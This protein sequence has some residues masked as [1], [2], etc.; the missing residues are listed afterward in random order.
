[1][2][3]FATLSIHP[4]LSF[5]Y[6]IHK[7]VLYVCISVAALQVGSSVPQTQYIIVAQKKTF[8]FKMTKPSVLEMRLCVTP[9][10]QERAQL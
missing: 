7:S 2:C 8:E 1:M 9:G 6:S 10:R 5:P 3:L 4:T